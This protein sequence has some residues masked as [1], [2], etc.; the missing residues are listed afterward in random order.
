[1][2]LNKLVQSREILSPAITA[3]AIKTVEANCPIDYLVTA[4]GVKDIRSPP[5]DDRLG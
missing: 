1:M 2:F 3:D 5:W 4:W